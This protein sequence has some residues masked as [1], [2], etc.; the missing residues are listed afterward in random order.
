MTLAEFR[1]LTSHLAGERE[2]LCAGAPVGL[3][4]HDE[5]ACVS[6]DDEA[7]YQLGDEP[8]VVVLF[9]GEQPTAGLDAANLELLVAA[10]EVK[11]EQTV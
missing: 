6:I 3:L 4:W 8:S 2:L 9:A 5:R 7:G 1:R 11:E 10:E